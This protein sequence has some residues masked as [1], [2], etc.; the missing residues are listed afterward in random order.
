[1]WLI[2]LAKVSTEK[3]LTATTFL[4]SFATSYEY[5]TMTVRKEVR[6]IQLKELA[7]ELLM[8]RVFILGT[9]RPLL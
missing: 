7:H 5:D 1:L 6:L 2:L 3:E 8:R 9:S 4:V